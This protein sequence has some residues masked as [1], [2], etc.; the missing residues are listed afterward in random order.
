MDRLTLWGD[1]CVGERHSG[2]MNLD[3]DA[4]F[5]SR[6]PISIQKPAPALNRAPVE[7][8]PVLNNVQDVVQYIKE[9]RKEWNK[10]REAVNQHVAKMFPCD[11]AFDGSDQDL[12]VSILS[13]LMKKVLS[14]PDIDWRFVHKPSLEDALMVLNETSPTIKRLDEINFQFS[15]G[16]ANI[17]DFNFE[18]Y[19][20]AFASCY[21]P[22]RIQQLAYSL[23]C[24]RI[25]SFLRIRSDGQSLEQTKHG[26]AFKFK[27]HFR[28]SSGNNRFDISSDFERSHR[29]MIISFAEILRLGSLEE[30]AAEMEEFKGII[31]GYMNLPFDVNTTKGNFKLKIFKNG[32]ITYTIP[33][34]AAKKLQIFLA[35]YGANDSN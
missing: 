1:D 18:K 10:Q 15:R 27:E 33:D 32:N 6:S 2:L 8:E 19:E 21:N 30:L 4:L 26:V 22:K 16:K 35:K 24:N 34:A 7:E 5:N 13:G 9:K 25:K 23:H 20:Q 29:E 28:L 31:E 3:L 14:N 12:L 17:Q 11:F